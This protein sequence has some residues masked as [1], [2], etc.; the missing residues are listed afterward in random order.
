MA[1]L[2]EIRAARATLA[3][4][5]LAGD[6]EVLAALA[7]H[8][9]VD[10]LARLAGRDEP[11]DRR[12]TQRPGTGGEPV[13]GDATDMVRRAARAGARLVIPEDDE[14]PT[15]LPDL[16]ATPA[17]EGRGGALCLWVRGDPPVR[18]AL[19]HAVAVVGA[20][21]ATP[22]G[23]QVAEQLGYDLAAAGWTVLSTGAYGIDGAGLRG[24][25]TGGGPVAAVLPA[26][27]DRPYPSG[28]ADL[29]D[30][31]AGN[32]VLVSPW[33]PGTTP[34]R[35]QFAATSRLVAALA[36]GT[37]L[38]EATLRSTSLHALDQALRLGRPAMVIPGPVTS[39]LS[40]GPHQALR[41]RRQARLVR[42]AAD[43]IAEL[44]PPAEDTH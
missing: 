39:T 36:R 23:T 10:A 31:I 6:P 44:A 5:A 18:T 43:V 30:R 12:G 27:V 20:R 14:W 25:L 38:V 22:Y 26:G 4:G 11:V 19:H 37:V 35:A 16:A 32:G 7:A 21:A 42:G 9:P 29:F 3:A 41:A 40:T 1:G 15:T 28:N 17:A 24:A 33:P 13:R 34:T 8:G 2:D